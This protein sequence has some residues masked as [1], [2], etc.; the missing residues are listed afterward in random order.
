MLT[1]VELS[2]VCCEITMDSPFETRMPIVLL[3]FK[4]MEGGIKP[5]SIF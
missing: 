3:T 5:P 1:A 4:K 2:S